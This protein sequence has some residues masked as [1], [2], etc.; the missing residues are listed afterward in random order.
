MRPTAGR[1]V[2][3][4]PRSGPDADRGHCNADRTHIANFTVGAETP[5]FEHGLVRALAS[6][7]DPALRDRWLGPLCRGE[8]RAGVVFAGLIPGPPR[9]RATPVDGGWELLDF[10]RLNFHSA[11]NLYGTQPFPPRVW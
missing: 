9:L 8:L 5:Q 6:G 10:S 7:D 2:G 11:K 3:P 1:R 4:V